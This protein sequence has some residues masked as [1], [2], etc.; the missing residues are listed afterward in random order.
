MPGYK[1]IHQGHICSKHGGLLIYLND[2]FTYDQRTLYKHSD[3]WEGVFIDVSGPSLN[4]PLTIGNIYRPPHDNNDNENI[5]KFIAELS[6]IIDLLQ[7]ENMYSTVVGDFNINLLQ[8]NEREKFSEFFDMMCTNSFFPKI[9]LP[10]RY[11]THSC[12]LIDQMFCKV[13]HQQ[14]IDISSS[15]IISRISDHFPC[16]VNLRTPGEGRKQEKLIYTRII[17]DS[18][19]NDFH[20]ELSRLDI[21]SRLN[22]NLLSDPNIDYG[23]FEEVLCASF[24]KHFPEKRIKLINTSINCRP[25]LHL[26]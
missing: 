22:A 17:N 18:A 3:I 10:T 26:E 2:D 12:S 23:K 15:I 14:E 19:I 20:E 21:P 11:G 25:G 5:S 24:N 16:I 8:I 7:S 13:P 9:T 1:L 4:R 6:P